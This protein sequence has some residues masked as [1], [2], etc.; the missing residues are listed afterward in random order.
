MVL[1]AVLALSQ[2]SG[3]TRWVSG[4]RG[5]HGHL[6]CPHWVG[7]SLAMPPSVPL[8]RLRGGTRR[9]PRTYSPC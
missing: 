2:G 9:A 5:G 1:L 8:G 7:L 4:P 6:R 3:V